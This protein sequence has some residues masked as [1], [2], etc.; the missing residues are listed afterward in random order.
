MFDVTLVAVVLE[1]SRSEMLVEIRA[2]GNWRVV[3]ELVSGSWT[4]MSASGR[5]GLSALNWCRR[6]R[7]LR[8]PRDGRCLHYAHI[9]DLCAL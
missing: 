2:L 8:A 1:G 4:L 9:P 6:S 7:H 5:Y 3:K